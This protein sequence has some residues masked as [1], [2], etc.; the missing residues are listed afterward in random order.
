MNFSANPKLFVESDLAGKYGRELKLSIEIFIMEFAFLL[1]GQKLDYSWTRDNLKE[2]AVQFF[3]EY[4]KKLTEIQKC[5][6]NEQNK[7]I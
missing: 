1:T 2:E 3:R 6:I 5:N 4:R 7:D